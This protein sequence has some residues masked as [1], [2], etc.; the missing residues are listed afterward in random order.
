M[1]YTKNYNLKKPAA[2]DYYNIADFNAN[3]DTIDEKLL[4][5][6]NALTLANQLLSRVE[7]LEN[8]FSLLAQKARI[9]VTI[10]GPSGCLVCLTS[11]NSSYTATIGSSMEVTL[12]ADNIGVSQVQFTYKNTSYVVEMQMDN[13]EH[14]FVAAP[15][16]LEQAPWSYIAKVSEQ[17]LAQTCWRVGD[18]KELN[19]DG[20]AAN[21]HI[22]D[23]EHDILYTPAEPPLVTARKDF[24]KAGITFGLVDILPTKYQM[25]SSKDVSVNWGTC[26]MRLKT[27][28]SLLA[29]M[30]AGL[31]PV[32]KTVR[33]VTALPHANHDN[34]DYAWAADGKA[35]ITDDQLFLFSER[36]LYGSHRC[37]SPYIVY[38]TPAYD[39]YRQGGTVERS[40]SFWLRNYNYNS[41]SGVYNTL[42]VATDNT[43]SNR[44]NNYQLGVLFGFCV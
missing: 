22:L 19:V 29:T 39:Y 24:T 20:A 1:D 28:P 15:I 4:L 33:K 16:P 38:E 26:D 18:T 43:I 44:L 35:Q 25:H 30:D 7:I 11:G 9:V 21:V 40:D 34:S 27:L 31:Q 41:S 12:T 14:R 5:G 8:N 2:E 36:D 37:S 3:S 17:G 23:F 42:C 10:Y 6:D 13:T 32:I